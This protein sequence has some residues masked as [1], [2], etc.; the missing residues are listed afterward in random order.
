VTCGGSRLLPA[1][2]SQCRVASSHFQ[3]PHTPPHD[4]Q[5]QL[6]TNTPSI[7]HLTR[8]NVWR[9]DYIFAITAK[10]GAGITV[11]PPGSTRIANRI[12]TADGY[13]GEF[14][15]LCRVWKCCRIRVLLLESRV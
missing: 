8:Q 4:T 10:D 2:L 1:T 3:S 13:L 5:H 9:D 12:T 11:A 15:G 14:F 6:T 7:P